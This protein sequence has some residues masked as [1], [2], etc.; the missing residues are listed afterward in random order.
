MKHILSI[1]LCFLLVAGVAL[2]DSPATPTD[3]EEEEYYI[4][5]DYDGGRIDIEILERKVFL[6]FLKEPK[7]YGDEV[8]L[9]QFIVYAC[10]Y[11]ERNVLVFLT[12]CSF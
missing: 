1:L 3:L 12:E 5:D 8:I 4:F 9:V 11:K 2:S 6:E 7:H 10:V